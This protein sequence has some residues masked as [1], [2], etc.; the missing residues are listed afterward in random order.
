MTPQG[1]QTKR[2][3]A[4]EFTSQTVCLGGECQTGQ[5]VGVLQQTTYF[6]QRGQLIFFILFL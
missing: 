6:L 1:C 2:L 3:W 4:V 5:S